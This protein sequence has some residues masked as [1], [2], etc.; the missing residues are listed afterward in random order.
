MQKKY[1]P[2]GHLYDPSI[3]GDQCPMCAQPATGGPA[4]APRPA[5][6]L[7]TNISGGA[8]AMGGGQAA[9]NGGHTR[10]A[11][12]P[13]GGQSPAAAPYNAPA[14]P[15]SQNMNGETRMRPQSAEPKPAHPGGTVIR[16]QPAAG[17]KATAGR[18]LVGFLVTYN[19]SPLGRAYNIYE[20]RNFIGR[21]ASCDISVPDDVQMSGRHLSI[22]YRAADNKFKF[23]DE[24][25]SNGTYIN[26]EII[27]EGE[28]SNY[29]IIRAG[30]TIFIFIAI[31][32]IG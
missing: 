24:Q 28:L 5:Q 18:R 15:Q 13:A 32:K 4:G 17:G 20:G 30:S 14:K 12:A 23:R 9:N 22:L 29:D 21:D 19:R 31:P 16:M 3:Y 7:K 27:D 25:S 26:K 8:P 10:I 11:G 1:C 2:N 6:P